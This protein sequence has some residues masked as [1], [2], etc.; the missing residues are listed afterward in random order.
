M[1]DEF[2]L[3]K[4]KQTTK[5]CFSFKQL[6]FMAEN[7]NIVRDMFAVMMKKNDYYLNV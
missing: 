5:N 2:Y 7:I 1:G 3:A 6:I 4:A